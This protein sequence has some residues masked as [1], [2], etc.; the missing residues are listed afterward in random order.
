M[1]KGKSRFGNK[2][3]R[4]EGRWWVGAHDGERPPYSIALA[5]GMSRAFPFCAPEQSGLAGT[6][7]PPCRLGVTY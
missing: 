2:T 5:A 6:G 7:D 1:Q 4:E 3:G